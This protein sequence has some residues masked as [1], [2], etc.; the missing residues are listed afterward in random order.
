MYRIQQPP[1]DYRMLPLSVGKGKWGRV[2]PNQPL[3]DAALG[4]DIDIDTDLIYIYRYRHRYRL[5]YMFLGAAVLAAS[6]FKRQVF[7]CACR[8][9]P[10]PAAFQ[11]WQL[12]LR[13][14]K[15]VKQAWQEA[16]TTTSSMLL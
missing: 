7:A 1:V 3:K 9:P 13:V 5:L 11:K 12:R 10:V 4:I 6:R 8:F 15:C 14:R 2:D 16:H